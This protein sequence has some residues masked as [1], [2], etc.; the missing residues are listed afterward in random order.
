[1][2]I[3][4]R[5]GHEIKVNPI[6]CADARFVIFWDLFEQGWETSTFET[7]DKYLTPETTYVDLGAWIGPTVLYAAQICKQCYAFEPDP[8]AYR[9]LKANVEVNG[10][11]NVTTV[12]AA[13]LDY[14]G[15]AVFGNDDLC[16]SMTRVGHPNKLFDVACV[17]LETFANRY[18]T[19]TKPLFIK[20]D[21]EGAE[22]LVFRSM[23][24]FKTYKPTVFVSLHLPW[25]QNEIEALKTIHAV[26][27]LYKYQIPIDSGTSYLFT[28]E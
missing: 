15:M 27:K 6:E 5:N 7:F 4:H 28:E 13:I 24:F 16:N 25:F 12:N 23:D 20:V 21:V 1:M 9:Q 17:T 14:D 10:F 26:G 3:V 8:L 2:R 11:K 22:E 18:A 19:L